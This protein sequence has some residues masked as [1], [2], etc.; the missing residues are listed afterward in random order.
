MDWHKQFSIQASWT[1]GIREFFFTQCCTENFGRILDVGCGT[2]VLETELKTKLRADLFGL[3]NDFE[4]LI[5]ARK[6][7]EINQWICADAHDLPFS[8]GAFDLVFCHY[9]LLW[10]GDPLRV[11]KEMMRLTR[12]EGI[13]AAFAEPD[14]RGRID[15]PDPLSRLAEWQRESL[16]IQGANPDMGRQLKAIFVAAGLQ[17]V[18]AG[19]L[20]AQWSS[21]PVDSDFDSEWDLIDF[22]LQSLSDSIPKWQITRL[23]EIDRLS[24]RKGERILFVP[25][26][27]A[28]GKVSKSV[29][30]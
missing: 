10:I 9:L 5:E 7:V 26:F 3:D 22:D 15:Y 29:K 24:R 13:V 25:T 14:Y 4:S 6:H 19:I 27:Y 28:W 16:R 8:S 20:G 23:K 11:V 17:D 12:N 1:K 21:S 18:Q 30:S 2:G